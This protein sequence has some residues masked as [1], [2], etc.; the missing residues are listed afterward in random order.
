MWTLEKYTDEGESGSDP[1]LGDPCPFGSPVC[2]CGGDRAVDGG[3]RASWTGSSTELSLGHVGGE[4]AL[5]RAERWPIYH[6]QH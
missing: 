4:E 6:T 2:V 1:K 3:L 5:L